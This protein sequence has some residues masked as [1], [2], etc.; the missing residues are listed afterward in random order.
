[1]EPNSACPI[2]TMTDILVSS[3]GHAEC[4]TCGHEWEADSGDAG[5]IGPNGIGPV[6]DAN[7]V[8]LQDG[9]SVTLIKSLKLGGSSDM[10]KI[11]TKVN[12]IRLVA[13]DHEIDCKVAGRGVLLKAKFVKKA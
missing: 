2:C 3:A 10:L 12:N 11:G 9:D 7:G 8:V 5:G 13:G 4:V 1:M 6:K